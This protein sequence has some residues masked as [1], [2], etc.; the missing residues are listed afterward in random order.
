MRLHA[1]IQTNKIFL[2]KRISYRC[3]IKA[4]QCWLI[5]IGDN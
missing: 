5:L 2:R 1:K 3:Y 4:N